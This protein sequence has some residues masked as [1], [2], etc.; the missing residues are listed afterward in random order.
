MVTLVPLQHP[1]QGLL[2][3]CRLHGVTMKLKPKTNQ[4]LLGAA[5]LLS[6][7][8]DIWFAD[9]LPHQSSATAKQKHLTPQFSVRPL[10]SW[11]NL[12]Q[13]WWEHSKFHVSTV[14]AEIIADMAALQSLAPQS[15]VI[16]KGKTAWASVQGGAEKAVLCLTLKQLNG[17]W[18]PPFV[19]NNI[20]LQV[21][22]SC[23]VPT[24]SS[25]KIRVQCRLYS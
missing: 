5:L 14:T 4:L 3:P 24:K 11:W 22:I 6:V 10:G 7:N 25:V 8:S 12:L 19:T 13:L 9:E 18:Q 21:P 20:S 17:D 2:Y 15:Q 16:Y 1:M 23:P